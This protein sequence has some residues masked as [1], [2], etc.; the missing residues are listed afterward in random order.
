MIN[1][2][3][4]LLASLLLLIAFGC[5]AQ[6]ITGSWSSVPTFGNNY[7]MVVETPSRIYALANGAL[8]SIS[9]TET[10]IYDRQNK[11]S[12]YDIT[13]IRYNY[14]KGYLFIGYSNGNIDLLYDD[15]HIVNMPAL[16]DA[17]LAT[18]HEI[19]NVDF[20]QD[21]IAVAT[22]FGIV[23]LDD[24]TYEVVESGI[25]NVEVNNALILGNRLMVYA[26][27]KLYI[28]PLSERHSQLSSFGHVTNGTSQAGMWDNIARVG[29]DSFIRAC[30]NPANTV[31]FYAV[32]ADGKLTGKKVAD[33]TQAKTFSYADGIVALTNYWE[34]VLVDGQGNAQKVSIPTALRGTASFTGGSPASVWVAGAKGVAHYNLTTS[35]PTMLSDWYKPNASPVIR[36]AD[37]VWSADGQQLYISHVGQSHSLPEKLDVNMQVCSMDRQG[38]IANLSFQ[39]PRSVRRLAVDPQDADV[40]YYA[41]GYN[42]FGVYNHEG[43]V[44]FVGPDDYQHGD[45]NYS[46]RT[47]CTF[48]FDP[49]NNLWVTNLTKEG[50]PC[51]SMLPRKNNATYDWS[52]ITK[53]DWKVH[54]AKTTNKNVTW[55]SKLLFS[56]HS[57]YMVMFSASFGFMVIHHNNTLTDFSDDSYCV[58]ENPVDQTGAEVAHG[59]LFCGVE[60]KKGAFWFGSFFG[61]LVLDNPADGLD[62][63]CPLRR[64]LVARNDG[65]NYGD[66][67][68][69]TDRIYCIAVDHTNRKWIGTENSG[70]YLVSEDGSEI[71]EHFT[72][73]NSPLPSNAIY[74]VSVDPLS[75]AVYIGTES[76]LYVYNSTS[77][78]AADDYSE[79]N[80][81]PNPV[82]P[83]YTGWITVTGLMDNSLVKIADAMGNV[84]YTG[85]SEG[86]TMVWDGCN[87]AGERVRSGVYFI[88]ASQN[89]NGTS[90]AVAKITVIN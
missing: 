75:S 83:E 70:L 90:G 48:T 13:L 3:F 89:Q 71:L 21:R 56:S 54:P 40:F 57:P 11:L 88:L 19:N 59:R 23:I 85:T 6:S 51:L 77:S 38:N 87:S 39:G 12:D 66:Y 80:V 67:L 33:D 46:M 55:E 32:D 78:P 44:K 60:D 24:T 62:A 65:T 69:S 42:G 22:K 68:L 5:G 50:V 17:T 86:G 49:E 25:Y 47:P 72:S 9:D 53:S 37:L 63:S 73:I 10:M 31:Y 18:S 76:G 82:R 43:L 15:D 52:E 14:D 28:S 84:V 81:Y 64:P 16:K 1:R 26:G 27:N 20:G 34:Q 41:Y 35:T 8:V 61:V 2:T 30:S 29:N 36:P 7:S 58:H 79:V 45:P 4:R 74:A